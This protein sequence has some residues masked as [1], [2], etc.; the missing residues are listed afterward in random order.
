MSKGAKVNLTQVKARLAQVESDARRYETELAR[1]MPRA[2]GAPLERL[3]RLNQILIRSE[4]ALTL[5]EGLPGR[6]WYKHQIYAPGLYTGYSAKTLPGIRE[7]I[8]AGRIRE[9]QAQAASVARVLGALSSQIREAI[10]AL[11]R[12]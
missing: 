2:S 5:P 11:R 12:L 8:E 7:A 10:Q 4:R 1:A 3:T 9:A 6:N